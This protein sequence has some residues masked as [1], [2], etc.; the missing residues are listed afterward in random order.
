MKYVIYD[1]F[2]QPKT[3]KTTLLAATDAKKRFGP[4]AYYK[5]QPTKKS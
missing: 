4:K 5:I 2:D 3:V 1:Q